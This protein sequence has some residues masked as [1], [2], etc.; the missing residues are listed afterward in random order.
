MNLYSKLILNKE[1]SVR[2]IRSILD[3]VGHMQKNEK[4]EKV[5]I[6][7]TPKNLRNIIT[8]QK[9]KNSYLKLIKENG[10]ATHKMIAKDINMSL[11]T[12]KRNSKVL[13]NL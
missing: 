6:T 12:I 4:V 13:K 10:I 7:R 1:L 5:K 3:E 11:T 2:E 9:I 8:C